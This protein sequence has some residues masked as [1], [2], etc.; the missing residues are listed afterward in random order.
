MGMKLYKC[1]HCPNTSGSRVCER[2]R[3]LAEQ[4][5][6]VNY[7]GPIRAGDKFTGIVGF[8]W[9]AEGCQPGWVRLYRPGSD[10]EEHGHTV[11]VEVR[12]LRALGLK[13]EN[14]CGQ[15]VVGPEQHP[16]PKTTRQPS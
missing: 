5:W 15:V 11:M 14:P 6:P 3:Y 7:A 9:D 16:D 12:V 13:T 2:C 1:K 8:V 4:G 10:Q